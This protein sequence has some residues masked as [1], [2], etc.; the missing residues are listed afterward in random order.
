MYGKRLCSIPS[1]NSRV[2]YLTLFIELGQRNE[3]FVMLYSVK[4]SKDRTEQV[5]IRCLGLTPFLVAVRRLWHRSFLEMAVEFHLWL[6]TDFIFLVPVV[7]HRYNDSVS[8][9]LLLQFWI[10]LNCEKVRLCNTCNYF[11]HNRS[12]MR[13]HWSTRCSPRE[14]VV[15]IAKAGRG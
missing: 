5:E 3:H 2:Y 1:S 12:Y 11:A 13:S 7:G 15:K 4:W 9:W 14:E 6:V 8:I 10:C